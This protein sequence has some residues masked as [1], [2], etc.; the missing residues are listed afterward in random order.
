MTDVGWLWPL[1]GVAEQL[2]GQNIV[3]RGLGLG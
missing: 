3:S 2:F 1:L